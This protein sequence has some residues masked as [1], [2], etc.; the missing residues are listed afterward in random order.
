MLH[1]RHLEE[2]GEIIYDVEH[3]YSN[4]LQEH[5][6]VKIVFKLDDVDDDNA[7]TMKDKLSSW[8]TS[9]D[10]MSVSYPFVIIPYSLSHQLIDIVA[11]L[12]LEPW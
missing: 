3:R 2:D 7:E 5:K 9:L 4:Y 10:H 12:I 8:K 6:G 11:C 1:R